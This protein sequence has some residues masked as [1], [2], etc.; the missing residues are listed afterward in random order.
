MSLRSQLVLGTAAWTTGLVVIV[1]WVSLTLI[2]GRGGMHL[3]IAAMLLLAVGAMAAGLWQVRR[4]VSS[5]N[6]L[7]AKLSAVHD[8]R[9]TRLDGVY[10]PEAQP[11]ADD[12]HSMLEHREQAGS[13]AIAKGGGLA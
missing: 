2:R 1:N 10:P 11:L 8:G 6:R 13:R 4:S 5:L 3:H 12:L 9:Q 7:R